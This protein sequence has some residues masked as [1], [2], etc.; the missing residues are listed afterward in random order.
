MVDTAVA[1]M[2]VR[3]SDR[4]AVGVQSEEVGGAPMTSDHR[5]L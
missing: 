4:F 5:A 1:R 3:V 2:C